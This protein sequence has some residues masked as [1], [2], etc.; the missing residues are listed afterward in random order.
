[1]REDV[2]KWNVQGTRGK[3]VQCSWSTEGKSLL[4]LEILEISSCHRTFAHAVLSSWNVLP[5]GTVLAYLLTSFLLQ[6]NVTHSV[7]P[8][9]TSLLKIPP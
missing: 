3:T 1:M 5:L 9:L 6:L 8:P 4:V 2:F 7:K